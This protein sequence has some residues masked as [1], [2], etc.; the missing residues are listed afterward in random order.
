M[1]TLSYSPFH[2]G[3]FGGYISQMYV[4]KAEQLKVNNMNKEIINF[5]IA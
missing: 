2:I 5:F 4:A 3:W 1:S